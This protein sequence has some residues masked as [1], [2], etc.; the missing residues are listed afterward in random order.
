MLIIGGFFALMNPFV[1]TVAAE[2]MAAWFFLIGG[3]LQ[4]GAAFRAGGWGARLLGILLGVAYVVLGF[5]L[6][7]HPLAGIVT[8]TV[9]AAIMFLVN[10][11]LKIVFA[12]SL[13]GSGFFWL[14]L[15]S[16]AI[17]V[18]LAVIVFGNFLAASVSLLGIL[19]A[20]E[21]I[22]SGVTMLSYGSYVRK[23]PEAELA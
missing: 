13:R 14:S 7:F 16:G 5:G 4:F 3:V 11:V 12:F 19:L 10:G 17:S 6:L 2:Q 8:L 15:L 1:A 21:L 22:S 18:V 9:M 23:H 20:I